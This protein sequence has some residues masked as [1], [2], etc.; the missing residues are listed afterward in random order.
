MRRHKTNKCIISFH[1][2][3]NIDMKI[4]L[5]RKCSSYYAF[6]MPHKKHLADLF[7]L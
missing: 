3:K 7:I 5:M 2:N 4:I 1:N 6:E